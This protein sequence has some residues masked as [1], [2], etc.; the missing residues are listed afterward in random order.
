MLN[1]NRY[2]ASTGELLSSTQIT[3]NKP[4]GSPNSSASIDG[5][6]SASPR[7]ERNHQ[8]K[9]LSRTTTKSKT[10]M[11]TAVAKPAAPVKKS[12][13]QTVK[14]D[15][16]RPS[17]APSPVRQERAKQV[18][19]SSL[20]SKFGSE[21]KRITKYSSLPVAKEPTKELPPTHAPAVLIASAK[22]STREPNTK[23]S[24]ESALQNATSH[25]NA[26]IKKKPR[27]HK[28]ASKLKI[29]PSLLNVS[30]LFL[31]FLVIGGYFAYNNVPNLAMRVAS[32]RSG[33]DGDIPDYQ[34]AG[35][36]I[37]GA[38][39]YQPGQIVI[40]YGSHSDER[41]YTV[42]ERNSEWNSETLL[43]NHV[44]VNRRPYQTVQDKGKTIYMYDGDSASWVDKG[45][46]YEVD[47]NT[48]LNTD[49]VLRVANSL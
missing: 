33:I 14:S 41:S 25:H 23:Q 30:L 31:T 21:V 11:R 47:G 19:R 26:K 6:V 7:K 3:S 2:D 27:L 16:S 34:P 29:A 39:K 12:N 45:I 28:V 43:E 42:T 5:F 4:S 10:L 17:V 49:Q 9:P 24:F 20:I 13:T 48:S 46:W 8:P 38:I 35:F 44:A 40:T 15:I 22:S 1:G 18:K 37:K 32:T 36:S